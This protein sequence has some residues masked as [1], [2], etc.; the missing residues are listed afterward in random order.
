[1]Q[2]VMKDGSA[3]KDNGW[4]TSKKTQIE[5]ATVEAEETAGNNLISEVM[6]VQLPA[7]SRLRSAL[8]AVPA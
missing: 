4:R 5:A 6:A 1:M 8:L 2:G 7:F 3:R